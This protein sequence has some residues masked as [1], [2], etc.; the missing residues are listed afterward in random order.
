[1]TVFRVVTVCSE[2]SPKRT[3]LSFDPYW[4]IGLPGGV[5][6][7]KY[8]PLPKSFSFSPTRK[9]KGLN[10]PRQDLNY[11]RRPHEPR[12]SNGFLRKTALTVTD[13]E[14]LATLAVLFYLSLVVDDVGSLVVYEEVGGAR[15]LQPCFESRPELGIL[16]WLL[17]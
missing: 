6:L 7:M 15:A 13:K 9:S 8:T 14:F 2:I 10:M 12:N 4:L 16:E 3:S 17:K 1:M 11:L 5:H